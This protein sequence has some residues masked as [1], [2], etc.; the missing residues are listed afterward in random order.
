MSKQPY[1]QETLG[2]LR[3]RNKKKNNPDPDPPGKKKIEFWA[4]RI[5]DPKLFAEFRVPD[6]AS[7]VSDLISKGSKITMGRYKKS[8]KWGIQ[9]ILIDKK[10]TKTKAQSLAKLIKK[11]IEG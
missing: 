3:K 7:K 11:R 2:F 5:R 4:I 1:G 6:W 9:R 8:K 10:F